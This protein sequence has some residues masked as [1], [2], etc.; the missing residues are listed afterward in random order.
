MDKCSPHA[1]LRRMTPLY[2]LIGFVIVGMV[3]I[4]WKQHTTQ[5]S[6]DPRLKAELDKKNQDI[7]E[8]KNQITEIKSEKDKL[9]GQGKELYDRYKSLES[10]YKAVSKERDTLSGRINKFE[11]QEDQRQLRHEDM[12]TKLEEAKSALEDERT[13]I[14]REDEQKLQRELEERDRMWN[15]HEQ[16]VIAQLAELCKKPQFGFTA[17]DNANLPEGFHG[18]L[19]PD[20]M[21]GFLNQYVIFDAKV[22]RSQ[23]LQNYVKDAV[24]KTAKKVKGVEE[25][26][27]TLFLVVPTEAIGELKQTSFYEEGFSFYVISPEAL[28]PVFAG[29]KKLENYEFAKEMDPQ[30]RE[31]IVDML[32]NFDYHISTRN[33]VDYHLLQHGI[34]T[35]AKLRGKDSDLLEEVIIKRQ[36]MRHL[37]FNTAET[38]QLS[39][40]PQMVHDKLLEL[41]EPKAKLSREELKRMG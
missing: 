5:E 38:K 4:G 27:P 35:L 40:D 3:Y 25:I 36:K 21:I 41:T 6:G 15:E 11:T 18:S 26:Y 34:E 9:T 14:R 37:N 2:I 29:L 7:G 33:A 31:N 12:A 39:S 8:L 32:A 22:S 16:R 30:E 19:K 10:E 28:E 17:Y 24:K 23:D 20:F 1:T 13:R